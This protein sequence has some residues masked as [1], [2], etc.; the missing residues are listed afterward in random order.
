MPGF[1]RQGHAR[2][3]KK[4]QLDGHG[5]AAQGVEVRTRTCA[6]SDLACTLLLETATLAWPLPAASSTASM[7][8]MLSAVC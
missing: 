8:A 6:A 7:R 5:L 4:Q 3:Y 2:E 1:A